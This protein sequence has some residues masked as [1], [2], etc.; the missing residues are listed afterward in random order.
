MRNLEFEQESAHSIAIESSH[1]LFKQLGARLNAD[2]ILHC[3][4]CLHELD[5]GIF[6]LTLNPR[7][8]EIGAHFLCSF[9]K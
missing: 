4:R 8:V 3:L 9:G 7:L 6:G 2:L 1:L 5:K